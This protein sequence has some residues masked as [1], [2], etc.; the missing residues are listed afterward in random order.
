[1]S[2]TDS[3]LIELEQLL[4]ERDALRASES[5][6]E[7]VKYTM[8]EYDVTWF[9]K[10]YIEILDKF[11]KGEFKRLIVSIGPQFGKSEISSRRLP[12]FL[13]GLDPNLKICLA[14]YNQPFAS[15]FNRSVQRIVDSEN[16]HKVFPE[17]YLNES[18][19]V[20][21]SSSWLR[22]SEEFEV[23][24]HKGSFKAVGVT[25]GITGN[26]VDVFIMDDLYKGY[27]E[28]NSPAVSDS[29]WGVYISEIKSRLH[30]QSRELIVYTRW[31]EN[32]TV[33]RLE[34]MGKVYTLKPDDNIDELDLPEDV[35]LKINFESLKET[36]PNNLDHREVGESLWEGR[37]SRVKLESVREMDNQRF[38][39]LYQGNPR[40]KEG[41]MYGEF[42]EYDHLPPMKIIKNY[43][44]TADE[45]KDYLCSIS[46][47]VPLKGD[48]LYLLD[49]VYTQKAMEITEPMT[50]E[51]MERNGVRE[52]KIES[53]NGGK[54]F[55]RNVDRLSNNSVNTTWFHQSKNKQARIFTNSAS[56]S[57]TVLMP[58]GWKT[59][60]P[61]FYSA[62][63]NHKKD[64]KNK[65]DDAADCIT[66]VYEEEFSKQKPIEIVW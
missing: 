55:A 40:S 23:V 9:H 51:H 44:D 1:M 61:E 5:L 10:T 59:R 54:G 18:N 37:H 24:G 20:M 12:A 49:V 46:Y 32:D 53:N 66:G 39:A 35:F 52:A 13:L 42:G 4:D 15:K 17:T 16:Y 33:G 6:L 29:V 21:V 2:I 58:I 26:T 50:A 11:A 47:G 31:S 60:H 41:L 62:L 65:H 64:A 57:R 19:V 38:Q 27:A 56:V 43:T 45:G 30:N 28:A 8:P 22:N 25:G 48:N 34:K 36:E 7:F 63:A 14:S 3:E